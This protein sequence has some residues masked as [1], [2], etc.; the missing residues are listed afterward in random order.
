VAR[1]GAPATDIDV[2]GVTW[3]EIDLL[4]RGL[5][6]RL[7]T[8]LR[9]SLLLHLA[10]DVRRGLS[11]QP[12]PPGD[13]GPWVRT[14]LE[15][16]RRFAEGGGRRV[17]IAGSCAEYDWNEG[18]CVEGK[19]PIRPATAYGAAKQA[20]CRLVSEYA[21]E[22]GLSLAWGRPFFVYGPHEHTE[23]FVPSVVRALLCGRPAECSH[24]K[25]IRD[26]LHVEDVATAFVALL[27]SDVQGPVNIASG[28]PVTLERIA[29]LA[30]E[31]VGRE[32]LLHFGVRP[33]AA[34]EAAR[35]AADVT[36][37][38]HEVGWNA[39][40]GLEAGLRHTIDWWKGAS[41]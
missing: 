29:T 33:V 11:R 40:Y 28:N 30:A 2:P 39:S 13:Y 34:D 22:H 19:T 6:E 9:P 37:L 3:H 5:V 1:R 41:H 7:L 23:R 18:P 14:G 10:W 12:L 15:L 35:I 24:G 20:L 17:V 27:R 31:I 16:V 21:A 8:E 36:R 4:K 38:T 25:Q 32:D 26:Y